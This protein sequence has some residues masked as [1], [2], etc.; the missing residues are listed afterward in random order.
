MSQVQTQ[1]IAE[2]GEAEDLATEAITDQAFL[3]LG[4]QTKV[5]STW[6]VGSTYAKNALVLEGA[7]AY[8]SL[9]AGNI[10]HKPSEDAD[11]AFWAPVAIA[12]SPLVNA[13]FGGTSYVS[14]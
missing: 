7:Q 1:T 8:R 11:F 5:P 2:A 14:G 9:V 13:G 10:G 6:L 12:V 4:V 3:P